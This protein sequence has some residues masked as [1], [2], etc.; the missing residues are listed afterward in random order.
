VPRGKVTIHQISF[1]RVSRYNW[2]A[3]PTEIS[4]R[5]GERKFVIFPYGIYEW[6]LEL[7]KLRIIARDGRT[8][9]SI[10]D[11]SPLCQTPIRL[12]ENGIP[13][14]ISSFKHLA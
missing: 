14:P 5:S 8:P 1:L 2:N 11:N 10:Q 9:W 6:V 4:E 12:R 7:C 3:A 13:Y